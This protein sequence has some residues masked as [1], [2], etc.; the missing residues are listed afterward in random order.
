[1]HGQSTSTDMGTTT[2][3][4]STEESTGIGTGT[5][6]VQVHTWGQVQPGNEYSLGKSTDVIHNHLLEPVLGLRT[7]V[8][9]VDKFALGWSE[10]NQTFLRG[11]APKESLIT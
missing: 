10:G 7:L 8:H 3:G 5:S 11:A 2:L 4:S 6:Y 1:M 9:T